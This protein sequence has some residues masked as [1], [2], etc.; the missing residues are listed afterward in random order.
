MFGK[1]MFTYSYCLQPNRFWFPQRLHGFH[2]LMWKISAGSSST[3]SHNILIACLLHYKHN[4]AQTTSRTIPIAK[5]STFPH[6]LP[7]PHM[8][9]HFCL[10]MQHSRPQGLVHHCHVLCG[11]YNIPTRLDMFCMGCGCSNGNN[12][13]GSNLINSVVDSILTRFDLDS[14]C[15][16]TLHFGLSSFVRE[17]LLHLQRKYKCLCLG[18]DS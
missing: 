1:S 8:L 17:T 15:I 18:V 13:V 12:I 16:T 14:L 3:H 5:T 4:P 2:K 10:H 9:T 6:T 11:K 7:L